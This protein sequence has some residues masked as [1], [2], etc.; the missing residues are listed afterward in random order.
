LHFFQTALIYNRLS[1]NE[2]CE[3]SIQTKLQPRIQFIFITKKYF[4]NLLFVTNTTQ[5]RAWFT[6]QA[7]ATMFT[8]FQRLL[9]K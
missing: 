5:V 9:E 8:F 7:N 4:L 3:P 6:A 2:K 1:E